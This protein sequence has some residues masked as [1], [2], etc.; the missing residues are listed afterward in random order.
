MSAAAVESS[1]WELTFDERPAR[2][3]IGLIVLATDHT[4]ERDFAAMRPSPEVA[5]YVTRILDH[6]GRNLD[7]RLTGPSG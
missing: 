4:A 3:R 5:V 1:G 7:R 2:W 6:L